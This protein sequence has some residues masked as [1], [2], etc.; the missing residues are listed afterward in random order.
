MGGTFKRKSL[1]KYKKVGR[2]Q[3]RVKIKSM[4]DMMLVKNDMLCFGYCAGY[5]DSER[6]RKRHLRSSYC[7]V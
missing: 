7:T 6:N 4:I 1:H 2:G 3:D 5:E